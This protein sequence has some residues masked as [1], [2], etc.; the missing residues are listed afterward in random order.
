[1]FDQ[2]FRRPKK[3]FFNQF[4]FGTFVRAEVLKNE[5]LCENDNFCGHQTTV[6]RACKFAK[7][8]EN[9]YALGHAPMGAIIFG[10]QNN[11]LF[12]GFEVQSNVELRTKS[13][14][15]PVLPSNFQ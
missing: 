14:F 7:N 5:V 11:N 4:F 1:M 10:F 8:Q 12:W 15:G 2:N 13:L 9:T 6:K 3:Y